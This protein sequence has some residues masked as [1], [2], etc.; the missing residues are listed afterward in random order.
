[1]QMIWTDDNKSLQK[2]KFLFPW[3]SIEK[4]QVHG[5]DVENLISLATNKAISIRV[6]K[7]NRIQ[8]TWTNSKEMVTRK[9]GDESKQNKTAK[10][11]L[12]IFFVLQSISAERR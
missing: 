9:N 11:S 12:L 6:L 8:V 2:P 7:I 4:F 5:K 1:M 10:C 3:T